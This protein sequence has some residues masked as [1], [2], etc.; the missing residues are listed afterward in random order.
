MLNEVTSLFDYFNKATKDKHYQSA[1][2][3]AYR[4]NFR[5]TIP[6][7]EAKKWINDWAK[8]SIGEHQPTCYSMVKFLNK[9]IKKINVASEKRKAMWAYKKSVKERLT[10]PLAVE[11]IAPATPPE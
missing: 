10:P 8:E 6:F 11:G 1:A 5:R 9:F 2:I 3:M 4:Y 7:K